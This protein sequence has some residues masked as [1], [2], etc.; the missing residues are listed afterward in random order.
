MK[1]F[2]AETNI[3][4]SRETIWDILTDAAGYPTWDP[5]TIRIEGTIAPG[6]RITAYSK[7][8]PKR[9]FPV[10]IADFIPGR[11]MIWAGG[12]PFGLFK[13][14][15][16][17]TL[18]TQRDGT[19]NFSLHEEFSGPLLPLIGRT[20]PDMTKTFEEFAAGLKA[21]AESTT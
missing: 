4:A 10:R 17:F 6:E 21:R 3:N 14:V 5:G 15:R 2:H 18:I 1:T 12:M 7:L 16:T 19:T 9:A 13:G 11:L 20:L 8:S